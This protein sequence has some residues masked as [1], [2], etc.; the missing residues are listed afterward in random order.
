MFNKYI[1]SSMNPGV[2]YFT[3]WTFKGGVLLIA[4]L[5]LAVAQCMNS[6]HDC[7][8]LRPQRSVPCIFPEGCAGKEWERMKGE[9]IKGG[10]NERAESESAKRWENGQKGDRV[11]V[12]GMLK[13][14]S[15]ALAPSRP[16]TLAPLLLEW[17]SHLVKILMPDIFTARKRSL[18]RGNVFTPVC[19]S[20]GDFH[21]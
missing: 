1:C 12:V 7:H 15:H 13:C 21:P 20:T 8:L 14:C 3:C 4:F 5:T 10:E 19:L 9:S 18:G 2:V 11:W 16:L 6:I 17:K